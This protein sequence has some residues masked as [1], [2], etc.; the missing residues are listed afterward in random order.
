[1][2]VLE[3]RVEAGDSICKVQVITTPNTPY[4]FRVSVSISHFE[5][6]GLTTSAEQHR[7]QLLGLRDTSV[8]HFTESR[9]GEMERVAE[10]LQFAVVVKRRRPSPCEL[11]LS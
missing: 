10:V 5:T 7:F 9:I 3:I 11:Q 2:E 1:L 8:K 4:A 6:V